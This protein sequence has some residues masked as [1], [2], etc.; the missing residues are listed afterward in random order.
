[1]D[2]VKGKT[3]EFEI[4]YQ[5]VLSPLSILVKE[6]EAMVLAVGHQNV[7][8]IINNNPG[9]VL[10]LAS[11][12]SGGSKFSDGFEIVGVENVDLIE[13]KIVDVQLAL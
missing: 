4:D 13:A 3:R 8:Q 12:S 9:K 5:I 10:E 2:L 11:S 7:P 1:M 6:T